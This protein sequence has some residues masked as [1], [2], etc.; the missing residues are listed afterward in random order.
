M[1]KGKYEKWLEP[2]S[3]ILLEA[4]ARDGL[5]DEQIA[6]NMGVNVATLYRY[7]QTYCEI[8]NALKRGKEIVDIIAEN[9]LYKKGLGFTKIVK[10]PI[11]VKEVLYKDGKRASEKEHIEYVDEEVFIPPDT[12]ALI[13]WLKNRK[14]IVWRDKPT[15]E[16]DEVLDK[17]DEL[18][19]G[20]R[21]DANSSYK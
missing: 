19:Q 20:I 3:L 7:K 14:P 11:K 1:A 8:C 6:S 17:I 16:N 13:F 10:K 21:D 5:T 15:V 18:L 12:T 2:D 4:W 9:A